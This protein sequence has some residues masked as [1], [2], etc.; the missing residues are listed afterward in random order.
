MVMV[1]LVVEMLLG[2]GGDHYSGGCDADGDE[3]DGGGDDQST[4]GDR[5]GCGLGVVV[6]VHSGGDG[7]GPCGR[8]GIA[9]GGDCVMVLVVMWLYGVDDGAGGGDVVEIVV[10]V[11]TVIVCWW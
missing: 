11:V 5:T 4:G 7:G 6:I 8:D 9:D 3:G 1:V 10:P 2:D